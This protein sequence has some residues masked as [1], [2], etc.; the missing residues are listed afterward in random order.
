VLRV[1]EMG[2]HLAMVDMGWKV[3]A[4]VPLFGGIG[5][6]PKPS[7]QVQ[8]TS[9]DLEWAVIKMANGNLNRI[10]QGSLVCK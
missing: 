6:G 1:A 5:E 2:D 4:A 3:G 8:D 9:T 7:K 10:E